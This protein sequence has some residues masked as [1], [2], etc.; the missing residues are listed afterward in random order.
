MIDRKIYCVWVGEN[1]AM[2]E[3]RINGL[4]SIR[5]NSGVEVVLVNNDNLNSFV[6]EGHPIHEGFKYLSD[7]HKSDYLRCYLMHH[8][9]GGYSDI[10]P[11]SW[12]WNIYFDRLEKGYDYGVGAPEDEGPLS[13]PLIIRKE[14][15][16]HW[17]K[18]ISADLF[19]FKPYTVFT[20]YWY[21]Q[22]MQRMDENLVPL[23]K[24]PATTSREAADT[25]VTKYPIRWAGILCE[26]FHPLC[27]NFTDRISKTMPLPIRDNYR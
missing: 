12:D 3:N 25:V 23:K 27:V 26:I 16:D 15:G 24:N 6:K 10:K 17:D 2:N 20:S 1:T 22:M 14:Y 18:M 8:Y 13:T 7:V 21:T 5:K 11:C 4:E 19:I 9:G